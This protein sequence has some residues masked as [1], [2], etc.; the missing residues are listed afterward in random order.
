MAAPESPR[1]A[2]SRRRRRLL[3]A[4][5]V[6]LALLVGVRAALPEVIRRVIESQASAA[7]GRKVAVE[8]VDLGLVM[9]RAQIDGLAV[10]GPDLAA[11]IDPAH[12]VV[13]LARAG[14][15]IA[16]L[17]LLTGKIHLR[18]IALTSPSLRLERNADGSLAP[19]VLAKPAP[20][21][22]PEPEAESGGI[23]VAI[24]RFSLDGAELQLVSAADAAAI[25]Q[26]RFEN[27]SVAD[28]SMHEGAF[29]VGAVSLRGPDLEVQSD[30][31]ATAAATP[32]VASAPPSNAPA[33]AEP[34][35][36]RASASP[37]SK[38]RVKDLN[39]EGARFGWRLANGD[40]V[41]AELEVH[42]RDLGLGNAPFPLEIR[43]TTDGAKFALEGQLAP[44]PLRF[45]GSFQW[46]G[47]RL[48]RLVRVAEQARLK[49]ASGKS[50]G[51]LAIA[52]SLEP[53]SAEKAPGVRV[54]GDF[55]IYDLELA[56]NDGALAAQWKD[57]AVAL[58]EVKVPLG[59]NPGAPDVHLA[60]IA[61][62]QPQLAFTLQKSSEAP[63]PAE[64]KPAD[65]P[66][67]DAGKAAPQPQVLVDAL[68]VS[69][70][71][72]QFKDTT[73]KPPVDTALTDLRIRA[74]G[75]RWPERDIAKLLLTAKGQQGSSLKIAGGMKGG[76]GD[77]DV[78]LKQLPLQ[79]FDPYAAN[80]SGIAI[81]QG[82][83][84]VTSKLALGKNSMG[85]KSVLSLHQL[86][87]SER[88]SGWFQAAFGVPLDVALALLRDMQGDITLPV[89]LE[90]NER[91]TQVGIAAAVTA[92]LRQALVGALSAPLK[93]LGAVAGK[94]GSVLSTGLEP[95]PMDPGQG[96]LDADEY[97]R[98]DALAKLLS[99]R[100]GLQVVLVGHADPSD[101]PSLARRVVLARAQAGEE[102]PGE[103]E[104]G[105]FER[106]RVR[107]ALA[108]ADPDAPDSLD[109]ETSA[110]LDRLA[111]Q[112]QVTDEARQALA[113]ARA[114]AVAQALQDEHGASAGA[115]AG[116]E[117]GVGAP[118]VAIELRASNQ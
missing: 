7:L 41:D 111:G 92:A 33:P 13:R 18:E 75:V 39:I 4:F 97:Q 72:L 67:A 66:P 102:L 89:D 87:V 25:A 54:D 53:A 46:E 19:L 115:V 83:L 84:S 105:F 30:R 100:P 80:A 68:E 21:P 108:D 22:E 79:P 12:A 95:I 86:S 94:A 38:S 114:Q 8:N 44:Q 91:G 118:G 104:L 93:M 88:E 16:W 32:E 76:A 6:V 58:D 109:A 48:D 2:V 107:S 9:G 47:A 113:L 64:E 82:R 63:A 26:L 98:V 42:A 24:D 23:D 27:L 36:A 15:Q 65:T 45:D 31:L 10:G 14:A 20:E 29:G 3:I 35:P 51:K 73:V 70:G 85:A 101:D 62:Q 110:A 78:E 90:Q 55:R 49:I 69:G 60:K 1:P 43:L 99:S 17:P 50:D 81:Q 117:T 71:K 56:S 34:Q 112:V 11:P 116:I 28:L 96:G 40:L 103:G 37:A 77:V 5:G 59:E 61:L 74:Q 57:L 106:R 52:L